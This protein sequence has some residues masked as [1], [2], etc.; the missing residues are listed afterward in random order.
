MAWR[1]QPRFRLDV[2]AADGHSLERDR[3]LQSS[4]L[5]IFQA[6]FFGSVGTLG[7]EG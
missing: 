4:Y 2:R 6:P 7:H 3:R 1:Y 5:M